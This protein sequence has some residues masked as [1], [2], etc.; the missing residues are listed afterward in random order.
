MSTTITFPPVAPALKL[1]SRQAANPPSEKW[2]ATL[3]EERRRLLEDQEALR[4]R[5]TN[6]RDYESRL[7]SLQ[8]EIEAARGAPPVTT[9]RPTAAPFVRPSSKAPFADD[10]ALQIAWEKLHRA[11]ELFEADQTHLRDERVVLHDQQA[12]LKQ[13]EAAVA[14]REARVAEREQLIAATNTCAMTGEPE[15]EPVADEHTMSAMTRLTRAPF[16]MAR[17]VFGGKK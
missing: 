12:D 17:S 10:Q 11:R 7:R 15:S 4:E 8:A 6:L 3:A 16:N 14:E 9:L 5:E 1:A 13:R 2:A